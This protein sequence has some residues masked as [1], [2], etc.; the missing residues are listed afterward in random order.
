MTNTD[1]QTDNA[2]LAIP[3]P[4]M[5]GIALVAA[6]VL[7]FLIPMHWLPEPGLTSVFSW[8]GVVVTAAAV[9]LGGWALRLFRAERTHPEPWKPTKTIVTSGPFRFTRNPMYLGMTGVLLGLSVMFALEWGIVLTPILL[10]AFDRMV[11]VREEA[12]LT[13][14]FGAT[15]QDLLA[16]TRR[17]L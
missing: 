8:L 16:R 3:P 13:R 14:K 15:Y 2:G 17:W 12:Y 5:L 4:A 10:L 6:V 1:L 7:E 9:A 11:V